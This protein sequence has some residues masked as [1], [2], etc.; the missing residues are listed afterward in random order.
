MVFAQQKRSYSTNRIS[1]EP[2]IDGVLDDAAW[3]DDNWQDNFTQ[4]EP[5]DGKPSTQN[6]SF[7]LVYT[8]NFIYVAIKSFDNEADKI[9]SR[10]MRSDNTG[11]DYVS[12]QIDSYHDKRTAFAFYVNAAGVK[13]DILFSN[14]GTV[15]DKNW[16]PIWYAKTTKDDKGWYAE[17]KIPLSQLRFSSSDDKVWGFEVMR[18]I[19]RNEE[20]SLWQPI[21]REKTGWV[22]S[23][24]ELRGIDNLKPK[25]IME[26]A[27][28]AL[29]GVENKRNDSENPYDNGAEFIHGLGVDGKIGITNDFVL[30]FTFN[31]DFGQVEA[32]PS[33][34]NLSAFETYQ[35][36]QRPFFVEG[37]NITD[38][39]ISPGDGG[40]SRDNLFYSRRIG[41]APQYYPE[42]GD[43]VDYPM[44]TKILGAL[45]LTG[46]T[47][48][49]LSVGIIESI[50][51]NEIARTTTNN[52]E[53]EQNIEPLTN[54]FVARVQ[55]DFDNGNTVV[56]GEVTSVNRKI[57]DDNLKFLPENAFS[58]GLDFAQYWKERSYFFKATVATS[59]I[60]GDSLAMIN[61]QSSSQRYFQ[62]PDADYLNMDSSITSM[63]GYGGDI[64]VGKS[65]A[66]GWYYNFRLST[67]TPGL[68]LNDM[69][70]IRQGDR[71]MTS[72]ENGYKWTTPK[73][74]YRNISTGI[75]VWHGLDF[76]GRTIFDG[77]FAWYNMQFKNRYSF[78]VNT[79]SEFNKHDNYMLRGGPTFYVPG[80]ASLRINLQSDRT[81][82]VY[83]DIGTHQSWGY[84]N[85][86]RSISYDAGVTYRP[87]D[88][89]SL[90]FHPNYSTSENNLQYVD[91]QVLGS[92][93][94]Y[95]LATIKRETLSL[96]FMVDYNISP[97]LT[98]QYYAAP[99]ISTG[100]YSDFKRV[101]N[102]NSDVYQDRFHQF[103]NE[104]ISYDE[105][106][107]EYSVDANNNGSTDY[108]ISNPDYN[109]KE[110]QSNLVLRWE[111]TPGSMIYLVWTQNRSQSDG[112]G[113]FRFSDDFDQ[114]FKQYP[115]DIIMLKFSYRF[116]K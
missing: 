91:E 78:N 87:F 42:T 10:L 59:Y 92:K 116:F 113:T 45:K 65:V 29:G 108:Q 1:K 103:T 74:F 44:S 100:K 98:I 82:K 52:I 104:E 84:D 43:Y 9:D 19:F 37:K 115:H 17:I 2:V 101:T 23:F 58:G 46:K 97:S 60:S 90:Q 35:Y 86:M 16:N 34:V 83:W 15:S 24:G 81:K 69:G 66:S 114:L 6:T 13:S 99:Y 73:Y 109:F 39:K 54:Y 48:E 80:D 8:D 93:P 63:Q 55:K 26:I 27:P 4:I 14:N 75:S 88:A 5:F 33:N 112:F 3:S 70:Y 30:D 71:V 64:S 102:A 47:K 67:R 110:F 11:G 53:S 51:R 96:R 77:F 20:T 105:S 107:E 25:R 68:S 111:F 85:N 56:G 32:D 12:V 36:E 31:P 95:V 61:R 28:Y 72:L 79:M 57:E 49:G 7:K 21:S 106:R 41:R 38:F 76:G 89:L 18:Y 94:D 62:R 50:T 22:Y 40:S